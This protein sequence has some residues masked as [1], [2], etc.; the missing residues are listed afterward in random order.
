MISMG[1]PLSP[2]RQS[3]AITGRKIEVSVLPLHVYYLYG[4][5]EVSVLPLVVYDLYGLAE[6]SVLPLVVYDLYGLASLSH[7]AYPAI[8]G[9]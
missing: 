3:P 4:L 5:T 6:V 8:P 2:I 9:R 1:S 7:Q